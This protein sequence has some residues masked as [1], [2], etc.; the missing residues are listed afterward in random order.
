[1]VVVLVLVDVAVRLVYVPRRLDGVSKIA[2]DGVRDT[3]YGR[4]LAVVFA[5]TERAVAAASASMVVVGDSTVMGKIGSPEGRLAPLIQRDFN[6]RPGTSKPIT[7][8][9]LGFLGLTAPDAAVVV[10]RALATRTDLVVLA[11]TPRVLCR[12]TAEAT[13]ARRHAMSWSIASRLGVGF[14]VEQFS[15]ATMAESAIRSHWALLCYQK[16]IRTELVTAVAPWLP[17]PWRKHIV[18][19]EDRANLGSEPAPLGEP[20]WTS[21]RCP[22]DDDSPEV[23]ALRRLL[24]ACQAERRCFVYAGPINPEGMDSFEPELLPRFRALIAR[25]TA[26]RGIPFRDYGDAL[27]ASA[28]RKPFMSRPDAIHVGESGRQWLAAELATQAHALLDAR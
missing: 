14:L 9:E 21:A 12:M 10:A 3:T 6:A 27:P 24:D 20:L 15:L 23:I 26:E 11:V 7:V 5:L 16:E 2:A 19:A 18:P 25:L 28:F 1:V 8:M 4:N 17:R 13:D 22:L